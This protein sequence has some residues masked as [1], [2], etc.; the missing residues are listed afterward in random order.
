M[1]ICTKGGRFMEEQLNE[2]QRPVN[3]RRKK[4]SQM[5]V[6]KEAYLP[7]II[8][9]LAIILTIVFIAGSITRASQRKKAEKAIQE[10]IE[11]SIADEKTSLEAEVDTLIAEA[12]TYAGQYDYQTAITILNSFSGDISQFT[13]LND[14]I[15]EY[16]RAQRET[17]EWNDPSQV[18]NLSFQMLI[19]DPARAFNYAGWSN[20]INRNFITTDEF[21]NMLQELYNNGYIL[22]DFDDF[23]TTETTA[24]G[25]TVYKAKSLY[26][27][28]GKKPL[29]L[30]QTNVNYNYYLIDTNKD[31][32]PDANGGGFAS[33]LLWDGQNFSCEMVDASGNTVTGDYDLIPILEK[34]IAANPDFSYH[35][36]RATI[37]LTGHNG[38]LGYRTHPAYS[39]NETNVSSA[40]SIFGTE[41]YQKDLQDA[42]AVIQA[43]RNAGYTV[44]CYTYSNTSYGSA[45]VSSIQS[46]LK[47]WT[48]SVT[49][50]LGETNV[51]TYAQMSDIAGKGDYS[52]D[53]FNALQDYGFRY[54]LGIC[55]DGQPW[56]LVADNYV[57]MGRIMVTGSNLAYHSEWFAD[58]FD[59][60]A[61]LDTT[62]GTVPQ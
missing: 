19:A 15:L 22:V 51:L 50:I 13:R 11:A 27:P 58:L 26:L 20:S 39:D 31:Y 12:E 42:A 1:Y 46:N 37:A 6:F 33:K 35:G 25:S 60:S 43:L 59:A 32:L 18:V 23:I 2:S 62:R 7:T 47:Y 17:V 4:R 38:L 28:A 36:A 56:A 49:P 9:G 53:K 54:Y 16:E 8:I 5:Q 57:R 41:K 48:D 30:T 34:F 14:K 3:P 52:G 55:T 44:S 45:S 21:S 10:S 61:I 40:E 29:M 24:S